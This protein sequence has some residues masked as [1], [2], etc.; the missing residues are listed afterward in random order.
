MQ[1]QKY[2]PN[3][4]TTTDAPA[5]WE[6]VKYWADVAGKFQQAS[7]AAQ[8]MAGFAL[9]ELRKQFH[10]QGKRNDLTSPHDVAKL[11]WQESVE[12]LAGIS[13]ETARR[14]ILMAEGIKS[15]WK[16]LTPQALL[17]EL[18]SVP[19]AD[20]TVDDT[21]VVSDALYKVTDGSTQLEFMRELGLA[22]LK[23]GNPNASGH[24]KRALSIGEQADVEKTLVAD[25]MNRILVDLDLLAG[26]FT[27]IPAPEIELFDAALMKHHRAMSQWLNSTDSKPA[28]ITKLFAR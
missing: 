1:L 4:V 14:W 19:V 18:M 8:V 26:R 7:L 22:K 16:K 17:R 6:Q 20:W 2:N 27:V 23:P 9:A 3:A 10:A 12:T 11:G 15:R 13:D 24:G 21:K 25:I 5:S 28:E